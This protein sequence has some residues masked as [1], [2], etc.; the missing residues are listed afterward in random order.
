MEP[1]DNTLFYAIQDVLEGLSIRKSARKLEV[2]RSTLHDRVS[3]KVINKNRG[4]Q[5]V[6]TAEE[7]GRF[8]AWLIE[9]CRLGLGVSKEEFVDVVQSFINK[10]DRKTMFNNENRPGESWYRGFLK[11]NPQVK[12]RAARTLDKKRAKI[13]PADLD[14]WYSDFEKF[15]NQF[16]LRNRPGQIWNCDESGFDLQRRAGNVM[17]PSKEKERLTES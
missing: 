15:V 6:L 12:L 8:A 9:R 14:E 4:R 3:G 1:N 11:Q 16:G 13:T 2:A 5:R 17:G 10:I 7:E